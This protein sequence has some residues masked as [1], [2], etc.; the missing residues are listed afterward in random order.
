MTPYPSLCP[1]SEMHSDALKQK[2]FRNEF[3]SMAIAVDWY[4]LQY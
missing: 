3:W 4:D 1:D 2:Q